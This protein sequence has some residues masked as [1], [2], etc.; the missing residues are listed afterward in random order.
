MKKNVTRAKILEFVI[1]FSLVFILTIAA[2][3]TDLDLS[4]SAYFFEASA[5]KWSDSSFVTFVYDYGPK[6]AVL[7]AFWAVFRLIL[8]YVVPNQFSHR[9]KSY[10]VIVSILLVPVFLTHVV[11]KDVW[12]R[13]RPRDTIEF[14]GNHDFLRILKISDHDF[15]GRS[16]PSGHAAAGFCLVFGYFLFKRKSGFLAR[17]TLSG[18][19][20]LGCLLSYA[21]IASGGHYFSDILWSF[22]LCWFS[23][24]ALYYCWFLPYEKRQ[25]RLDPF[26]FNRTR[27]YILGGIIG[28]CLVLWGTTNYM[29]ESFMIDLESFSIDIPSQAN[30][31]EIKGRVYKGNIKVVRMNRSDILIETWAKGNGPTGITVQRIINIDK[32]SDPLHISI[33][34][35]PSTWFWTY[36]SHLKIHVPRDVEFRWDLDT[37]LGEI[38]CPPSENCLGNRGIDK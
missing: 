21:R 31:I 37:R 29:I 36:Q 15:L 10:F 17:I 22:G 30:P 9:A 25:S 2:F 8:S 6:V 38:F 11:L 27:L 13:P 7:S 1:P 28:F 26:T 23:V 12:K 35:N 20:L 5:N 18:A 19:L 4:V 33:S 32:K 14:N 34:L 3:F 16:F 24:Y